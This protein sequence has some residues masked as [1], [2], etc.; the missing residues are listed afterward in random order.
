MSSTL[1]EASSSLQTKLERELLIAAA[2]DNLPRFT[3]LSTKGIS[4]HLLRTLLRVA[5]AKGAHLV[6]RYLVRHLKVD[7][8]M[9]F[10]D[11]KGTLFQRSVFIGQLSSAKL[12][13]ELGADVHKLTLLGSHP[14]H[15]AANR[16]HVHVVRYLIWD[17]GI[18]V[19]I[20]TRSKA[21]TPLHVAV[22]YGGSVEMVRCLV[23]EFGAN[24]FLE[25]KDG[26]TPF[27]T[28]IDKG[29][30][31]LLRI[32]LQAKADVPAT[33]SRQLST[34]TYT[35]VL[36]GNVSIFRMLCEHFK[37]FFT[38]VHA[39]AG[40]ILLQLAVDAN[41]PEIAR[42]LIEEFHVPV[43][44]MHTRHMRISTCAARTMHTLLSQYTLSIEFVD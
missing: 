39:D 33:N 2:D 24:P 20:M 1:R 21:W 38:K 13:R 44:H 5:Y 32:L 30:L 6:L 29:R 36:R 10:E 25:N 7:L 26:I 28:C 3:I 11:M 35:A 19:D 41:Q 27:L 23:G 17:L 15:L 9:V 22:N 34:A 37:L 4:S 18:Y 16:N 31:D 14:L 40:R 42:C 12:L 43:Q 8:D